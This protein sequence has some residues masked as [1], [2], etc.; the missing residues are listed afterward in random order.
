MV[1]AANDVSHAA[2]HVVNNNRKM[3]ERIIDPARDHKITQFG[4]IKRDLAAHLVHKRNNFPWIA[5]AHHLD[6]FARRILFLF[7]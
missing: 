3:I 7:L 1:F 6:H 5:Q 4:R 2:I